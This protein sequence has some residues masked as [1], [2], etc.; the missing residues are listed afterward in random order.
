LAEIISKI[1]GLVSKT[2]PMGSLMT[3]NGKLGYPK[4]SIRLNKIGLLA[5]QSVLERANSWFRG[6]LMP[7]LGAQTSHMGN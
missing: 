4:L 6:T 1:R 5:G 2:L 3:Q 7:I